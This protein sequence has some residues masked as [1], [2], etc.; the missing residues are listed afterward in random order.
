MAG[1][2]GASI[3]ELD[4]DSSELVEELGDI[5]KCIGGL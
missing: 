1:V 4:V 2:P 5:S 3:S